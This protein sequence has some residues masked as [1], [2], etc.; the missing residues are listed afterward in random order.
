[1]QNETHEKSQST[2]AP[3]QLAMEDLDQVKGGSGRT[4]AR[5]YGGTTSPPMGFPLTV[6]SPVAL[7]RR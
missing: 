5:P 7:T 1:M 6:A 4:P 3:Q 2:P